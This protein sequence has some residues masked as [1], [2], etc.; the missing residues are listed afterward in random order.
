MTLVEE[1]VQTRVLTALGEVPLNRC[2]GGSAANT[3]LGVAGFGGQAAYAGKVAGDELGE[4]CLAD[5]RKMGVAIDVP[6]AQGQTGSC[7]VL[8]SEDA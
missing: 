3:I 8:I 7:V 1:D 5:M 2:A 4:F 6:L